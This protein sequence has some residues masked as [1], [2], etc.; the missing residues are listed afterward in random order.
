M[1]HVGWIA[2][3]ALGLSLLAGCSSKASPGGSATPTTAGS[4]GGSTTVPFF[5]GSANSAYCSLARQFGQT[6]NPNTSSDPKV[7]FQQFDSLSSQLLIT[8]PSPIKDDATT[9]VNALKQL[10]TAFRAANFDA[11]KIKPTDLAPVEDPKFTDATTRID[12]YDSQ[13][14]GITTS[15]TG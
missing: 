8:V 6:L 7:L 11:T 4:A 2:G 5:T 9:V 10:E 12:A 13:V 15:T 1:R 3:A 14:C